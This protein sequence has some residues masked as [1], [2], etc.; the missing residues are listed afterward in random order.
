LILTSSTNADAVELVGEDIALML[1][2][3]G[4]VGAGFEGPDAAGAT[5]GRS[6]A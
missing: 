2:L 6:T 1:G 4:A 5:L 3:E